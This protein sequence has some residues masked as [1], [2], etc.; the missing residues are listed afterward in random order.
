MLEFVYDDKNIDNARITY[1]IYNIQLHNLGYVIGNCL[2]TGAMT[3]RFLSNPYTVC[4][5]FMCIFH[6]VF[7]FLARSA[8]R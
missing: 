8:A 6:C 7:M 1:M 3:R 2:M 5:V 4:F